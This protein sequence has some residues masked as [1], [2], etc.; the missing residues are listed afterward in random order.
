MKL[1]IYW[2]FFHFL[3]KNYS[4]DDFIHSGIK[5]HIILLNVKIIVIFP[6]YSLLFKELEES[7]IKQDQYRLGDFYIHVSLQDLRLNTKG[8]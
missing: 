1:Y 4:G 6:H 2:G 5:I 3:R 7:I 8:T